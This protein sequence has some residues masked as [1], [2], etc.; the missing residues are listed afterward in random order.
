LALITAGEVIG[1]TSLTRLDYFEPP[2]YQSEDRIEALYNMHDT[3][4][5]VARE[6]FPREPTLAAIEDATPSTLGSQLLRDEAITD[7]AVEAALQSDGLPE[8]VELNKSFLPAEYRSFEMYYE[9]PPL[10]AVYQTSLTNF[11]AVASR[12]HGIANLRINLVPRS[13]YRLA[14]R[15]GPMPPPWPVTIPAG[16]YDPFGV[17]KLGPPPPTQVEGRNWG[18]L[19]T[20]LGSQM[21]QGRADYARRTY[22]VFRRLELANPVAGLEWKV[23][24][25]D[26]TVMSGFGVPD[27]TLF[28]STG[29]VEKLTDDQLAAAMAHLMGHERYQHYPQNLRAGEQVQLLGSPRFFAEVPKYPDVLTLPQYGYSRWQEVDANRIAVEFLG[30]I[31][32]PPDT[33][34]DTLN[35]LSSDNSETVAAEWPSFS[36]IHH[37]PQTAADLARM[38]DAGIFRSPDGIADLSH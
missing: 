1:C 23:V 36:Q 5:A 38:L 27:G 31:D 7:S 10:T 22:Q 17:P 12:Y 33:L 30:R 24:L 6:D 4:V 19:A 11:D 29:L 25:F 3:P 14:L 16:A 28:V 26:S 8:A 15:T 34:F 37:L 13:V 32:I 18:Q 2:F 20:S 9:S 35:K 21:R